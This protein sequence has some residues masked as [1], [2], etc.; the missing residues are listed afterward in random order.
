MKEPVDP[1]GLR[2]AR[3]TPMRVALMLA[4]WF[5]AILIPLLAF[6]WW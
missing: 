1:A 3:F 6:I 4:V 2:P 5:V